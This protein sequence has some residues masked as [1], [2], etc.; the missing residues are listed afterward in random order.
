LVASNK[1]NIVFR[2]DASTQIGTGH[3]MRC[4]TLADALERTG[5]KCYFICR[6]HSGNLIATI[7]KYSHEVYSLPLDKPYQNDK[8]DSLDNKLDHANWLGTTQEIDAD[9][10]ISIVKLLKPDWVI[11]DHYAI[12]N[13][14][15]KKLRPY[16]SHMMVIDD[17][18]DRH[19]DCDLLLDQTFGREA[20]DYI[21]LLTKGCQLLCGSRFALLRPE[22]EQWRNFS[23]NLRKD[24]KMEHLLINLGGVDKDNVTSKIL[25]SL[26]NCRLPN[27]TRITVV[28]G[29]SAPWVSEVKNQ[30]KIMPWDTDV[31]VGVNNMAE[32]MANSDLSIGAAGATSWE[33]C[34]L[35][36][37]TIL[38]VLADNQKKIASNLV[39]AKATLVVDIDKLE[40]I[41]LIGESA[42]YPVVLRELSECAK[43]ITDGMGVSRVIK[44]L[45][46][47]FYSED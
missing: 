44:K 37:P 13:S 10:S 1:K 18:A 15:E 20:A 2:V 28:M 30:A 42:T 6:E 26:I 33:R 21:L 27:N 35:G 41:S 3:V 7:K 11:V 36:L 32:L 12:D 31:K 40:G 46:H 19:H 22:F 4:L 43:K 8:K 24:G 34:C 9:L 17:L 29:A 45:D 47:R 23:L 39:K 25:R 38:I 14:W 16:T 5:S